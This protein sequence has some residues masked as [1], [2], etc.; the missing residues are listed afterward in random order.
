MKFTLSTQELNYLINKIQN[1]VPNNQKPTLPILSNFLLEAFNNELI[2]TATDLNVS[3]RCKIEAQI[4]E[5][6]STTIPAKRFAQLARELTAPQVEI[7]CN[8]NEV[9]TIKTGDSI[10]KLNGMSR[11]SFPNLPEMDQAL[12]FEIEQKQLQEMLFQTS[13]A[14]SRDETRYVLTGVCMQVSNGMATFIGTDGRRLAKAHCPIN[15]DPSLAFQA[16]IPIKAVEE[17]EKN[18]MLEGTARITVS[19][20]KICVDCNNVRLIAKLLPGEYPDVYRVIPEKSDISLTIHREELLTLLRQISL[21]IPNSNHSVRFIFKEG[22]L[23]LNANTID[24][25]EG[26]VSMPVNYSG[27]SIEVAFNPTNFIDVLRH[28]KTEVVILGLT[29]PYNPGVI[30]EETT[31]DQKQASPLFIIMPMRLSE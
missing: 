16:V 11:E 7:L 14:V 17:I 18:L 24:V 4:T 8:S 9:T 2:L 20:D 15:A 26:K 1:V 23:L 22:E 31:A 10:F 12:T 13:F 29:D 25:G 27:A 3:I 21:F 19:P 30:T 6:G 5:E 28:C